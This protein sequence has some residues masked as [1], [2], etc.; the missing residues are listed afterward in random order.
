MLGSAV[1]SVCADQ[2]SL[3]IGTVTAQ[4]R[5]PRERRRRG[6]TAATGDIHESRRQLTWREG[7]ARW[8]PTGPTACGTPQADASRTDALANVKLHVGGNQTRV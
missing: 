8:G 4:A 7:G 2:V 1:R 6:A 5:G 3:L